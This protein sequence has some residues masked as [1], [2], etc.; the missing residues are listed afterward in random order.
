[1][2]KMEE[3]G[4]FEFQEICKRKPECY[5]PPRHMLNHELANIPEY[6]RRYFMELAK[7]SLLMQKPVHCREI[8]DA[9][10]ELEE[11]GKLKKK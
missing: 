11:K 4:E 6:L 7:K 2:N 5:C 3:L 1:M 9:L 10:T 8:D